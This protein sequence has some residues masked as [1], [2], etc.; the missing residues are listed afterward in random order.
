MIQ[1]IV[2]EMMKAKLNSLVPHIIDRI[3]KE[4]P[5]NNV[6]I[7]IQKNERKNQNTKK[8]N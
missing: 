2:R 6:I 5:K 7:I 8:S 3:E 1:S 4:K